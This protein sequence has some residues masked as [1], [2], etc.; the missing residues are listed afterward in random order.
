M[1]IWEKCFTG[2]VGKKGTFSG[3]GGWN[4]ILENHK[5]ALFHETKQQTSTV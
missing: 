4:N 5:G 3:R 1:L 2:F